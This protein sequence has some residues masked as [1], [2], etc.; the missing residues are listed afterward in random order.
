MI[1]ITGKDGNK[2]E[3][4]KHEYGFLQVSP[5]PNVA[6]LNLYYAQKYY[7]NPTVATYSLSYSEDELQLQI[8]AC[9]ITNQLFE[10]QFPNANKSLY[11]IGCGEGF[12][13]NGLMNCG[14]DVYGVDYSIAGIEKHNP[15]VLPFVNIGDAISDVEACIYS[16]RRFNLVNL[17]NVLEHVTDP[18]LLLEK[19]QK[20]LLPDGILRIVVPNDYSQLQELL[21]QQGSLDYEWVHPPDHLSYFNFDNLPKLLEATGFKVVNMLADFPIEFFLA[22]KHSNY[23]KDRSKGKDAHLSRVMLS[24]LIHQRGLDKY[25]KWSEGLAAAGIGRTCIAF[26]IIK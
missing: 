19:I 25:I 10:V 20:L 17:G 5:I 24:K 8:E 7:Q 1:K 23:I 13:M 4:I 15:S 22:N 16:K 12:F 2:Y 14:W 9:K 3:L 18:I 26:A 11:D 6:E 21:Q